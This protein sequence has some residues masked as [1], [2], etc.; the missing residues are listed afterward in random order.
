MLLPA[1][2][3]PAQLKEVPLTLRILKLL[4]DPNLLMLLFGAGIIGLGFELTHPGQVLPGVAGSVCLLLALYGLSVLPATGTRRLLVTTDP[5][6]YGRHF[7]DSL[8]PAA[9]AACK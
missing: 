9:A 5:V 6:I 4:V 3:T 1:S 2:V 7:D 8:T